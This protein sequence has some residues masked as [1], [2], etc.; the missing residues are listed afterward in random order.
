MAEQLAIP[1]NRFVEQRY[2]RLGSGIPGSKTGATINQDRVDI[3][4]CNPSRDHGANLVDIIRYD[5]SLYQNMAAFVQMLNQ[6]VT[7]AILVEATRIGNR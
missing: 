7:A 3:C 5:A 1:L 4:S 2:Q 6:Q